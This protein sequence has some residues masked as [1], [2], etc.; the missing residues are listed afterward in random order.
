VGIY[1]ERVVD[2]AADSDGLP[3]QGCS[4]AKHFESTLH[5]K[6]VLFLV[7]AGVLSAAGYTYFESAS[8]FAIY[9]A[10]VVVVVTG[11]YIWLNHSVATKSN[12]L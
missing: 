1:H 12:N 4:R 11:S 10:F 7:L 6:Q 2:C 8:D 3:Y 9:V 5:H